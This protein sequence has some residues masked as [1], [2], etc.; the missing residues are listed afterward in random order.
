MKTD[1]VVIFDNLQLTCSNFVK[2]WDQTNYTGKN[3]GIFTI[4]FHR[5]TVGCGCFL[6]APKFYHNF[7]SFYPILMF[8]TISESGDKTNNIADEFKTV[9]LIMIST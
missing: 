6:G 2:K 8:L 9:R 1:K 4:G 3:R 5:K 7:V